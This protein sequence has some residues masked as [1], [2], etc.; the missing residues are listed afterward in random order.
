MESL[1]LIVSTCLPIRFSNAL[2][3]KSR[4]SNS[5]LHD[6]LLGAGVEAAI[7]ALFAKSFGSGRRLLLTGTVLETGVWDE[8]ATSLE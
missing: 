2:M 6:M 5:W 3:C 7:P 8:I 4:V 1:S